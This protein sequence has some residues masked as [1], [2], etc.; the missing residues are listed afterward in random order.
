[1]AV[2]EWV[3]IYYL[4][5]PNL[6]DEGDNHLLEL[7]IAGNANYIVT[8]NIK[9]FKNTELMFPHILILKPDDFMRR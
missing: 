9:D 1:M 2:S 3:N 6:R 5:R 7:A 4:W 8:N